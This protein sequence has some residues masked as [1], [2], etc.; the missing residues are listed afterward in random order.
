MGKTIVDMSSSKIGRGISTNQ[1]E[2][3]QL[4]AKSV[5]DLL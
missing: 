3:D 4:E 5:F 1:D 2:A